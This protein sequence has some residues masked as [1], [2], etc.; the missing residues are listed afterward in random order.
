M[1]PQE[2][3]AVQLQDAQFV[4]NGECAVA[5]PGVGWLGRLSRELHWSFLLAAVSVYG[6]CQGVGDAINGVASGFYLK[7]VQPCSRRRRSSTRA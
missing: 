1:E 5:S 2:N 7:D 3:R 4:S 6:A